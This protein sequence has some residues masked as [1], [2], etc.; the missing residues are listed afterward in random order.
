MNLVSLL[1]A[2][3]VVQVSVGEDENTPLRIA[4]AL[5]SAAIIAGAVYVSKRR[6]VAIGESAPEPV[7]SNAA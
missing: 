6:P 2:A 5:V 4:I 3:A 1:I 7:G